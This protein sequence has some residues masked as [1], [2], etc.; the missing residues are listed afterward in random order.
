MIRLQ[1]NIRLFLWHRFFHDFLLIAPILIPFYQINH[2]GTFA[3]YLSQSTYALMV[4]IME[5]PSGYLAD[6][7]GRRNTLIIGALLF[8]LGLLLYSMSSTLPWFLAAELVMAVANSMRSGSDSALLFDSLSALSQENRYLDLEGRGQQYARM[9]TGIAS[10][11]GGLLAGLW[12]RL[13]F[14]INL[15]FSLVLIPLTLAMTEPPRRKAD[16]HNPLRQIFRIAAQT[17]RNPDIRPFILYI[18][19]IGCVS[20]IS[21]WAYFLYYQRVGIPTAW[22]GILFAGFQ[23]SAALGARLSSRMVKRIKPINLIICSL[24]IS[25]IMVL[26]AL[27]ESPLLILLILIHPLLWNMSLPLLF[28]QIN[29]RTNASIRATVLSLANMGVSLG[30]VLIGPV[31]GHFSDRISIVFCFLILAGFFLVS[32]A[33]LLIILNRIWRKPKNQLV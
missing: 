10:I 11:S 15:L 27:I 2:L 13:P 7:I 18:A 26:V 14:W 24:A 30:Y 16:G 28:E 12:L 20:I 29:I 17:M 31:F 8:P 5:V 21:L 9:G 22:F 33:W 3:F 32:A 4:L 23:F 1:R 6:V 19:I 25:P